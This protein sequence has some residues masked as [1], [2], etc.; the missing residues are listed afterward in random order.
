M[1]NFIF[2]CVVRNNWTQN[3][4]LQDMYDTQKNSA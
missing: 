4:D 1:E 3:D 2:C